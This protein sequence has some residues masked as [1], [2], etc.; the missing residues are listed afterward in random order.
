MN[1]RTSPE[2]SAAYR[3]PLGRFTLDLVA[4]E[5]FSEQ[6]QLAGLR[7]QGLELLLALGRRAGQV[8]SKDDL[9]RQVWPKVVVGEGS[10]TQAIAEVRRALGDDEHRLVRTVARRGY[11]LVPDGPAPAVDRGTPASAGPA[12]AEPVQAK[13]AAAASLTDTMAASPAAAVSA[14]GES[15]ALPAV[16]GGLEVLRSSSH[17]PRR[18]AAL[19]GAVALI[20]LLLAA[21]WLALR[22][23]GMSWLSPVDLARAPLP[24]EI[25]P[26]SI[27][28]L[29]LTLEGES[30]EA[31]WLAD[32]L[33][34][35]LVLAA[36]PAAASR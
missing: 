16:A 7:K 19:L 13:A 36:W 21:A 8:V 24:R 3:L 30:N 33:H 17:P 6:G 11:M 26:L 15:E 12:A 22:G 20:A 25:A 2:G 5:L 23:S 1:D 35:D 29:P 14:W 10:L 32:A 18:R 4:G 27:V 28:V 34:G 9:M 31:E